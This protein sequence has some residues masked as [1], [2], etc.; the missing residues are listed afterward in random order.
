MTTGCVG[1]IFSGIQGEGLLVG[2]RQVFIRLLGC[3]LR[4]AYCDTAWARE[5]ALGP[6]SRAARAE[7]TA[8]RRDFAE[9]AN[10]LE[11]VHTAEL[12]LR[13]DAPRGLHGW[14]SFTGGEPLLQPEFV[15]EVAWRVRSAGLRAYL[16]T[17]GTLAAPL[18]QVQDVVDA[19]AMDV[20]LPSAAGVEC[21]QAHAAFLAAARA[22]VERSALFVKA[23]FAD[24]TTEQEIERL[25]RLIAG[26]RAEVALVLQPVTQVN[27][28][29]APPS[30]GRMLALQAHAKRWLRQVRVIPQMHK[31]MGQM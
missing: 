26:V 21:W 23:V 10:P 6:A 15:R 22:L 25:C 29:P 27:G 17:N 11:A 14:A 7:R 3:N 2:E 19:V 13:L 8:G 24:T 31:L 4:C 28:G 18:A 5:R 20:K 30:P 12:T 16:E 1:E 9:H